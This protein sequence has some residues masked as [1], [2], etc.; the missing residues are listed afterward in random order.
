M[1]IECT[2]MAVVCRGIADEHWFCR[3]GICSLMFFVVL[4]F[5]CSFKIG[6]E[7]VSRYRVLPW[8][9]KGPQ[10]RSGTIFRVGSF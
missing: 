9:I 8:H 4:T 1:P 6:F 10:G 7:R 5:F 2:I 3:S